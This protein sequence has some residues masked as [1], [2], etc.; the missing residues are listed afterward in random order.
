M[1]VASTA[2]AYSSVCNSPYTTCDWYVEMYVAL[3][4]MSAYGWNQAGSWLRRT[5]PISRENI[6]SVA[7][8]ASTRSEKSRVGS[9]FVVSI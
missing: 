1:P 7:S 5:R 8:A 3:A 2:R 9:F 4:S 6:P